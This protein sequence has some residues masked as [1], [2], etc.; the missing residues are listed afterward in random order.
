MTHLATHPVLPTG[1]QLRP[2][3]AAKTLF[4]LLMKEYDLFLP[5]GDLGVIVCLSIKL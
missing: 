5:F 3:I 1:V 4:G 2:N